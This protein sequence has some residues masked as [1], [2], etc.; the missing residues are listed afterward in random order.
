MKRIVYLSLV[1]WRWIKQRPQF[2]AENLACYCDV[3]VIYPWRNRRKGLQKK[4]PS[5]VRQM[6]YFML[7]TLG[8]RFP[9][10]RTVNKGLAKIQI[11]LQLCGCRTD[12]LWLTLPEQL[13]W[14]PQEVDC[15]IIYDCM[16]DYAAM[17][18]Q[19]GRREIFLKQEE[20]LVHRAQCVFVSSQ[21]LM[22]LLIQR[23]HPPKEKLCLLRNGYSADWPS[24]Q[25]KST[26]EEELFCIGYFGTIGRWFDFAA[27][28]ASLNVCAEVEYHLYGPLE[29]GVAVP[30]HERLILHGV[31]EHDEIP[32]CAQ[33]MDALVMPFV[34]NEIVQ[35]VDPVKLYEYICLNKHIL[36]IHYPEIE[37][38]EPFVEF[39]DTKEAYIKQLQRL[40]KEKPSVKYSAQQA[41]EFLKENSWAMRAEQAVRHIERLMRRKQQ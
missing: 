13:E 7:P 36:S 30:D 15:P 29:K 38:F 20:A 19:K 16:D 2:I 9:I 11:H 17:D 12:C 10:I 37:R 41:E 8:G 18:M 5:P 24:V 33:R 14:L 31:V 26:R 23:Y 27:V 35:S 25:P 3:S 22:D 40:L 34:P 4:T 6:P 32:R 28:M 1:D 39:Y 21:H